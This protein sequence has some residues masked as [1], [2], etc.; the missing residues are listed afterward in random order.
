MSHKDRSNKMWGLNRSAATGQW[1]SLK[2]P[3][4]HLPFNVQVDETLPSGHRRWLNFLQHRDRR[5]QQSAA[6]GP[7]KVLRP[8]KEVED[9]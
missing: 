9:S 2:R 6:F 4:R 7:N 5:R 1:N 8:L 3:R